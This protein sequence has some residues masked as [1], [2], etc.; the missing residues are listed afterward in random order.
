[1]QNAS[2]VYTALYYGKTPDLF[3]TRRNLKITYVTK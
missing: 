1:M 3:H 2:E